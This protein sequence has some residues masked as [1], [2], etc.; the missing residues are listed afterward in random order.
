MQAKS[1]LLSIELTDAPG[2][3]G[4]SNDGAYRSLRWDDV[5]AIA[6]A[7]TAQVTLSADKVELSFAQIIPA[8][9]LTPD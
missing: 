9:P 1:V 7:E 5:N 8:V 2:R 3:T 4:F 6:A